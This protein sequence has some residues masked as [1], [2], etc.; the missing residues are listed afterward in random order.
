MVDDVAGGFLCLTVPRLKSGALV[1]E[2]GCRFEAAR[3]VGLIAGPLERLRCFA[4]HCTCLLAFPLSLAEDPRASHRAPV[5]SPPCHMPAMR[6]ASAMNERALSNSPARALA[7]AA[8]V[9]Y[10]IEQGS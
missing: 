8:L 7:A 5:H 4:E 3:G 2:R 10:P 6:S 1:A 9:R